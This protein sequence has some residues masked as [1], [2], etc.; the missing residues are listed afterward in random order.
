MRNYENIHTAVQIA[1]I[2]IGAAI[3]LSAILKKKSGEPKND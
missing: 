2:L 1:L 3:L